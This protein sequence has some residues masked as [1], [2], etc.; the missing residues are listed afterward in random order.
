V[1]ISNSEQ[2]RIPQA[3]EYLGLHLDHRLNWKKHILTKRK[4][5]GF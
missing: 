1:S 2:L 3:E 4:Q 5:L